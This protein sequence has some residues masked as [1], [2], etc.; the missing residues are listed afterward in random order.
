MQVKNG[1]RNATPPHLHG[2]V[3]SPLET[4][5]LRACDNVSVR[6]F[7]DPTIER[8]FRCGWSDLRYEAV[9]RNQLSVPRPGFTSPASYARITACTRSRRPSFSRMCPTCVL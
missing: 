7:G 8:Q 5:V 3:D 4:E 1:T 2:S 6:R 9:C